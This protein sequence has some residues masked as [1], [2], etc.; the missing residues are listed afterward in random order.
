MD[1]IKEKL[2]QFKAGIITHNEFYSTLED[3]HIHGALRDTFCNPDR[4]GFIGYNYDNQE[5]IDIKY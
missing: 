4:T 1:I 2:E 5:W 3:A